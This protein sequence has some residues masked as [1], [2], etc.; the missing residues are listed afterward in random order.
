[1]SEVTNLAVVG[2]GTMGAGV[3]QTALVAGMNVLLYDPSSQALTRALTSIALGLEKGH[4]KGLWALDPADVMSSKM[5][6]T[7]EIDDLASVDFVIETVPEELGL[8]HRV[9]QQVAAITRPRTVIASNTSSIP[10]T[11][12][13]S[14]IEDPTRVVGLHFFNPAP[15]MGLVEVI[16]AA[17][18]DAAAIRQATRLGEALGKRVIVAPD[19]PGFLVNRCGRGFYG[20]ALRLAAERIAEPRQID[21]ICRMAGR[22]PMGPFE[23]MD[24]VGIDVNFA[25]AKS[26]DELSFG[27][28]RWRP[29]AMQ[30]RMAASGNLGRKTGRGWYSYT[31]GPHRPV[32]PVPPMT[33]YGNGRALA[34][35]GAS[36]VAGLLRARGAQ[37]GFVL[38]DTSHDRVVATIFADLSAASDEVHG[39][40][41]PIVSCANASLSCR[42]LAHA[43]GFNIPN[44]ADQEHLVEITRTGNTPEGLANTAASVFACLGFHAEWV[45]D[46]PGLVFDRMLAQIINEAAFAYTEGIGT[47]ADIDAG[48]TIGLNYPR[49]PI[50]WG[51]AIGWGEILATLDAIWQERREERYR[52]AP[53]LLSAAA[54]VDLLP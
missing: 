47:A 11:L 45:S 34:I 17:Q 48:A 9:L 43:V 36:R 14:A 52:P 29:T 46:G 32:D 16:A 6:V 31:S 37:A 40:E 54:G 7:S 24:L 20:E 4:S 1:M 39:A 3:A 53:A 28:P 21:R 41:H 19:V 22:F 5:T 15:L 2:A 50:G 25:I 51:Y 12:I 33:G 42:Q 44:A 13:A 38:S 10:L 18:T 26:F 27:E 49:G 35:V 30:A 23:L 8:K